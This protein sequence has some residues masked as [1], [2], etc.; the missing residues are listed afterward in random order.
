[1]RLNLKEAFCVVRLLENKMK[2][3]RERFRSRLAK[4]RRRACNL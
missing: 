3:K 4:T 1:M 2:R